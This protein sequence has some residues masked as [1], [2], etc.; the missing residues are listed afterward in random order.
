MDIR[1]RVI[2]ALDVPDVA[3]AR[4]IVDTLGEE[5]T[6]YK[7][8][9]EL[10]F[11]GGLD[12]ARDLVASGKKVF[13]DL[14]LHDIPNTIEKGVG[15]IARMGMTFLTV[16]AYPQT[17]AAAAKG[18]AGSS[19]GVLGVSVMTSMD[20]GDLARAGYGMGVQ[21]LIARRARQIEEAGCRGIICSAVDIATVRRA[22]GESLA[23]VTPGIRPAGSALADQKRVMTPGEAIRAGVDNMVIGRP[24]TGAADPK[25]AM[26]SILDEIASAS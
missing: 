7:I 11:V 1:D 5:A 13:L 2:V 6:F 18:A 15:Q 9:Y 3:Q 19:L 14:K 8:G 16:H 10:A 22:V 4:S 17:L 23:I 25:T 26:R 20:D 12:F 24:I 21:D